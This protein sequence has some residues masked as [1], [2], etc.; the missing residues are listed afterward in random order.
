MR[1]T[2]R[3]SQEAAM[4]QVQEAADRR[5]REEAER[6]SQSERRRS[7]SLAAGGVGGGYELLSG[8]LTTAVAIGTMSASPTLRRFVLNASTVLLIV[9]AGAYGISLFFTGAH[10]LQTSQAWQGL[11]AIALFLA[12]MGIVAYIL[13]SFFAWIGRIVAGDWSKPT[14]AAAAP[15][16]AEETTEEA[17]VAVAKEFIDLV[18]R[19]KALARQRREMRRRNPADTDAMLESEQE[20]ADLL[21]RIAELVGGLDEK[22]VS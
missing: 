19:F 13:A 1:E 7:G 2:M 15:D 4:R 22:D 18:T 17:D 12:A 20:M 8:N 11:G 14:E 16:A 10:N 21:D 5:S 3:E 9:G 6:Q